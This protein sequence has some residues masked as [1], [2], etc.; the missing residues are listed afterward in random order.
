MAIPP[1][2]PVLEDNDIRQVLA[3]FST[4]LVADALKAHGSDRLVMR[5]I[6]AQGKLS[7]TVVGRARTLR[8]LPGRADVP[9]PASNLR[10]RFIDQVRQHE[11]LVFDAS[12]NPA[13]SVFGDMVAAR[14]T[15][16]GAAAIVVDGAIRDI[17]AINTIGL[18]A[19]STH[20][21]PAP[22]PSPLVAS[23]ADVP[24]QCGGVLVQTGDWILGDTDGVI[25]IPPSLVASVLEK[26]LA[27]TKRE[28]FSR[29]LLDRGHSLEQCFPL[30]A[31]LQVFFETYIKDG[32]LP[33]ASD[34]EAS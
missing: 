29:A 34:V 33:N 31:R 2:T 15:A 6:R 11:I 13:S 18:A 27:I 32:T 24:I 14:A 17:D 1:L 8:F 30:P 9:A 19:F 26:G 23:E 10:M 12:C 7:G 3:T 4:S 20:V 21:A 16:Q 25:V 22:H 5:T 28:E